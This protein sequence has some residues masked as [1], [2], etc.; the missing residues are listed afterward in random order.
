MIFQILDCNENTIM[1]HRE[2]FPDETE[3]PFILQKLVEANPDFIEF[4]RKPFAYFSAETNIW[5]NNQSGGYLDLIWIYGSD[6]VNGNVLMLKMLD[7]SIADNVSVK[8][9]LRPKMTIADIVYKVLGFYIYKNR[10]NS[11]TEG[12]RLVDRFGSLNGTLSAMGSS[13]RVS[14]QRRHTSTKMIARLIHHDFY[15]KHCKAMSVVYGSKTSRLDCCLESQHMLDQSVYRSAC[16][17][18]LISKDL[19]KIIY[20]NLPQRLKLIVGPFKVEIIA[21]VPQIGQG[22]GASVQPARREEDGAG[23]SVQGGGQNRPQAQKSAQTDQ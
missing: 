12:D 21:V 16:S 2:P 13:K 14:K 7:Y 22:Q 20:K 18:K 1:K 11:L 19:R 4:L 8:S 10:L 23:G 6:L 17:R 3:E 9:A 15:S 5:I